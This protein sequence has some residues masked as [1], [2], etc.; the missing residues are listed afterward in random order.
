VVD[1][2]PTPIRHGLDLA[3]QL[4]PAAARVVLSATTPDGL[5]PFLTVHSVDGAR[6]WVLN[7]RTFSAEDY[8]AVGEVL[9]PPR[10]LGILELPR[11]AV[12][13][14]RKAFNSSLTFAL[15]APA[16]VVM[17]PFGEANMVVHNYTASPQDIQVGFKVR[18]ANGL[19]DRLG[20][21]N[22][23]V[24]DGPVSLTLPPRSRVWLA[25]AQ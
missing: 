10:P 6:V 19:R 11:S 22:L 24:S 20:G 18:A 14:V 15:D 5:V 2:S 23:P 17:Q 12:N 7:I 13:I 25:P 1:D 21:N 8:R 4:E 9:L 16:R 3:G